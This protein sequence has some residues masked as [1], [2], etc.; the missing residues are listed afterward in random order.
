MQTVEDIIRRAQRLLGTIGSSDNAPVG[1]TT[2]ALEAYNSLQR[3]LFGGNPVGVR[4]DPQPAPTGTLVRHGALYQAGLAVATL[5]MPAIAREGF[6]FGVAMRG[7]SALTLSGGALIEGG[8]SV[9]LNTA[10]EYQYF[11]RGDTGTFRRVI[12]QALTDAPLFP[13]DLHDALAAML[14]FR[15]AAEFGEGQ[16]MAASIPKLADQAA[17]AFA[18]RYG[19]RGRNAPDQPFSLLNRRAATGAAAV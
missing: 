12:D 19:R 2:D 14:A 9:T 17:Q 1:E 7:T 13:A 15:L 4:L 11:Y 3:G 18:V 6:N 5:T 8:A 16:T 10:G